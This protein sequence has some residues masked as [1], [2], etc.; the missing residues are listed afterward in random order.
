LMKMKGH[1]GLCPCRMCNIIGIRIQTAGSKN[2]CHYI[3]L[4]RNELNS[5]YSA[6]DLPSRTHA[7]FMSD[8]DHVDNAP[9]PAEADRR[10]KMCGI[11][12]VPILA[13]LS[14]L[15]F[16]F[17]FPYDFMHLV[18][19]N[20]VKSL[21]LLWTG[22]FK[23]LKPDS[24]QPYRIG[25]SVWD[26]IGRATAEAG[27]TVPSAFGCRV[28][29][30]SERRSEFSAEAYSNWTTFLAP[31]LLREFLNE[32]YYAHFVKLVSLLTVSTRDELSRNDITLLRSG[33]SSCV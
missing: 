10:A 32:E 6:T 25:K 33:F 1:N 13:A 29:N 18:W 11:K 23:P 4:H 7:Q 17:S 14:S 27:S 28:P 5:S 12:G 9:N 2:N 30:I 31:V 8:A 16:P 24:N 21:I 19:E 22:E 20:V 15:E 26:A 3:P